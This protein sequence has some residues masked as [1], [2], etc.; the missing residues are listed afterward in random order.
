[1]VLLSIVVASSGQVFLQPG[2]TTLPLW[3]GLCT[4]SGVCYEASLPCN[5]NPSL[6]ITTCTSITFVSGTTLSNLTWNFSGSI[7]NISSQDVVTLGA[8]NV[9]FVNS[10]NVTLQDFQMTLNSPATFSFGGAVNTSSFSYESGPGI[11][12]AGAITYSSFVGPD[13]GCFPLVLLNV[14]TGTHLLQYSSFSGVFVYFADP[15]NEGLNIWNSAVT[16][17]IVNATGITDIRDCVWTNTVLQST[18]SVPMYT[19]SLSA[20]IYSNSTFY[21]PVNNVAV[22]DLTLYNTSFIGA[23]VYTFFHA[24][25]NLTM[26]ADTPHIVFEGYYYGSLLQMISPVIS[27]ISSGSVTLW[28]GAPE[29]V[30]L[31][32]FAPNMPINWSAPLTYYQGLRLTDVP[33]NAPLNLSSAGPGA[34]FFATYSNFTC[35]SEYCISFSG[36]GN[37]IGAQWTGNLFFGNTPRC[38]MHF[39]GSLFI[40]T[41]LVLDSICADPEQNGTI[42]VPTS[43]TAL[44]IKQSI[45]SGGSI[46]FTGQPPVLHNITTYA[47]INASTGSIFYLPPEGSP[48][49]S[50]ITV[51]S[52]DFLVATINV[53]WPYPAEPD[54]D[55]SY[56]L[57]TLTSSTTTL[58]NASSTNRNITLVTTSSGID[59]IFNAF[60]CSSKCVSGQY[61]ASVACTNADV[62]QCIPPWGGPYCQ[63]DTTLMP[64]GFECSP[65]GGLVWQYITAPPNSGV[66]SYTYNSPVYV[67]PAYALALPST[68]FTFTADVVLNRS[69]IQGYSLLTFL[70]NLTV[71]AVLNQTVYGPGS[72]AVYPETTVVAYSISFNAPLSA[73]FDF[74]KIDTAISCVNTSATAPAL[75]TYSR[76][77]YYPPQVL[78]INVAFI[79]DNSATS[80]DF[81]VNLAPVPLAPYFLPAFSFS[82]PSASLCASNITIALPSSESLL[83]VRLS[84][85]GMPSSTSPSPQSP[86][87]PAT[88]P[89]SSPPPSGSSPDANFTPDSGSP[90]VAPS[91]PPMTPLPPSAYLPS[92]PIFVDAPSAALSLAPSLILAIVTM[93]VALLFA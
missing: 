74:S 16:D 50:G 32:F 18:A 88:P 86:D 27:V 55:V 53:L 85:C 80:A 6:T 39:A 87:S 44:E 78:P 12:I 59:M 35:S 29:D 36:H 24:R 70:G 47:S 89:S 91:S 56:P 38:Q 51:V 9:T 17:A 57:L 28:T 63:C 76:D 42:M 20:G 58:N 3:D 48:T 5:A 68:Y 73:V 30:L 46:T 8:E 83:A 19:L 25:C 33:L 71:H 69:S 37:S 77:Y 61:N 43:T 65:N 64:S 72:C 14:P 11:F 49:G 4:G 52:S 40:G 67:P 13:V 81:S 62:C 79:D 34:A 2:N 41:P 92:S 1:M 45:G 66:I 60:P 31:Q 21:G 90:V 75:L 15:I 54:A 84:T 26:P 23:F 22:A 7:V 93:L 10:A 82:T